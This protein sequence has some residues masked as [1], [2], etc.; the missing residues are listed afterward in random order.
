MTNTGSVYVRFLNRKNITWRDSRA[1]ALPRAGGLRGRRVAAPAGEWSERPAD[2]RLGR[3]AVRVGGADIAVSV[4]GVAGPGGG[5]DDKPVG[6]VCFGFSIHGRVTTSTQ[7]FSGD[8]AAVRAKTVRFA[9]DEMIA[10]LS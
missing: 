1:P 5:S 10:A 7:Q 2:A 6:M 9:L 3:G 4:S 8:R